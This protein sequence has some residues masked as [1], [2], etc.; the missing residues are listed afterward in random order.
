MAESKVIG[1]SFFLRIDTGSAEAYIVCEQNSSLSISSEVITVLCKTTGEWA[2][3]LAGGTKSGSISFT[4]I[5]VKDPTNP[6]ISAFD[7]LALVG[8]VQDVIW[9]GA[10]SGDDVVEA[11]AHISEV[12][13][14]SNT[15]EAIQFSATLTI[16]GEP[17]ITTY[18]T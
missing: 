5:Y 3:I 4:G 10:G 9:G 1:N 8:T 16:A 12:N 17:T 11:S 15:N 14:D 2:E 18:T 13:L 7:L 6:N